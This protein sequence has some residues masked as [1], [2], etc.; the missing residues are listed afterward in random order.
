MASDTKGPSFGTAFTPHML[1]QRFANSAWS[2]AEIVPFGPF[3]LSPATVVFHYGQEIFEGFKVYR[4]PDGSA[5]MFRPDRNLAR[6][7]ASAERLC[8]PVLDP[9]AAIANICQ[10][11]KTDKD[12]IPSRPQ[13]LYVRPCMFATDAVIKVNPSSTYTYF[14]LLC[15]VG[16]YFGGD[17]PLGVRL[18]TEI[19]FVRAAPGGTGAAKCG[20][21]YAGSLAAQGQAAKDGFDQVVWLD[22]KERK[23][24]EEMGG[25][26]IM[27]VIDD[28]L[29]TPAIASGSI[30]PGVT[31]DSLLQLARSIGR[32]VEERAVSTDELI[33][34]QKAGRLKEAFACG[35]AAAITPIREIVHRG[36]LLFRNNTG[37][38]GALTMQ[39][40]QQL[41]DLQFGTALDPFGWRYPVKM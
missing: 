6:M 23:Y 1:V 32:K 21:N 29:V 16:E 22:G 12:K 31:R 41:L 34:A 39:L 38:P 28:A 4:Q 13:T 27:F 35:T 5:C 11:I 37:K 36:E 18:R 10:L 2:P 33:A 20:G 25:M 3:T 7:N 15:V 30:L 19:E 8:M 14:V 24:I 17:N 26:N 40:R 9:V